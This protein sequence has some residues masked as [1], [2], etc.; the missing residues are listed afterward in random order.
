MVLDKQLNKKI[1]KYPEISKFIKRIEIDGSNYWELIRE[2]IKE[3]N[4]SNGYMDSEY[5]FYMSQ[6]FQYSGELMED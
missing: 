6:I 2:E 1:L 5:L 4:H 3:F